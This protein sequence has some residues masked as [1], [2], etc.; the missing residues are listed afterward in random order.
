MMLLEDGLGEAQLR[1]TPNHTIEISVTPK[2]PEQFI[3]YPRC[4]TNYSTELI[5]EIFEAVGSV[6]LCDEILRDESPEYVSR[7]LTYGLFPFVEPS[8][9]QEKRLL[10]FGCGSGASTMV[11]SRLLPKTSLVG[12]E[13]EPPLLKIARSRAAFYGRTDI[14]FV[15]SPDPNT[16]PDQLGTF[17]FV[18][19]S[20]VFEHLLPKERQ[21]L[22]P[23]LWRQLNPGGV[24]FIN[25]TPHRYFP[26]ELHTTSGLPL[27]NYLPDSAASVYAKSVSR[28]NLQNYTW[29]QLLRK[30]IRGGS[31]KEVL[32]LIR[33]ES[34][35]FELL[36]PIHHGV[37][38][39]LD[40]WLQQTNTRPISRAKSAFARIAKLFQN[41]FGVAIVPELSI[42]IKK[43]E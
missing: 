15:A 8:E 41:C 25:Q 31:T 9:F 22:V 38:N 1:A 7:F 29:E 23:R 36:S 35:D 37:S 24:L 27:L 26:V 43:P 40:R 17:D 14:D 6:A 30:G 11:L 33:T 21:D 28:R 42:A 16:M 13:L 2:H 34:D 32:N 19:L 10:D 12:L 5:K 4:T 20:A 39:H 3:P 18:V